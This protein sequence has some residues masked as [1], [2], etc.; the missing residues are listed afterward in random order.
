MVH[1][2]LYTKIT[3]FSLVLLAR[4]L[5]MLRH[6]VKLFKIKLTNK[7]TPCLTVEMELVR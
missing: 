3:Q 6:D 4:S 1:Y 2:I 5:A 7:D